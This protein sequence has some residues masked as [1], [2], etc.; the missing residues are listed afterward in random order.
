[1]DNNK[2]KVFCLSFRTPPAIRPQAILIGKMIPEWIR[3]GISPVILTYESEGTWDIGV[4]VYKIS[5]FSI[6]KYLNRIPPVRMFLRRRYYNKLVKICLKIIKKH[7][8]NLVFSFSNPQESNILGAIIKDKTGL[9]FVSHF[10]DPWYN[11]PLGKVSNRS[12]KRILKQERR[13]LEKSDKVIFVN[14]KLKN[15]VMK[16]HPKELFLKAEIVPH[17]YDLSDYPLKEKSAREKFIFSYIGVFYKERNPGVFFESLR[18]ML[19]AN[20]VLVDKFKVELI[21]A[22]NNYSGFPEEG[23]RRMIK[24]YGFTDQV[25]IIPGVSYKESLKYMKMSDCLLVID[26]DIADSPF[27]PSKVVDY[28]GSGTPILGITPVGSPTDIF[29]RQLG[30]RVFNY[31]QIDALAEHLVRLIRGE[32]GGEINKDYLGQFS[33]INTTKKLLGIFREVTKGKK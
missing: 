20:P 12:A 10:S 22:V 21:G 16:N 7:N 6:N 25:E 17:C 24:D 18:R 19:K 3:Q 1:M 28:A 4:P 27:L 11:T 29:L 32:A 9:P 5:K 31:S 26:A 8:L 13:V 15:F 2:I 30:S 23:I 33:V 14:D